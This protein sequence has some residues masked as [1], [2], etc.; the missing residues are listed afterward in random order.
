MS[1]DSVWGPGN[2]SGFLP[3]KKTQLSEKRAFTWDED[4]FSGDPWHQN[5]ELLKFMGSSKQLSDLSII[6]FPWRHEK[7]TA[8]RQ[9][10]N[11]KILN[12]KRL[13]EINSE[14]YFLS[15]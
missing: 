10:R 5:Y 7:R 6:D 2:D 13:E 8:H 14:I 1:R 9:R 11:P 12:P 3:G 4:V 15:V